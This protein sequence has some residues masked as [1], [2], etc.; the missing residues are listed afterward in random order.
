MAE[1]YHQR[2]PERSVFYRVLF[3]YFDSFLLEYEN[4]FEREYGYLRPVVQEVV[5]KY[6]DC[7]NPKCG[8]ARIRCPDC[9]TARL[10]AFSC[11]VRGFCPSCHAKRIE[12]WGE[13]MREELILDT[14]HRQVVF[15]IPKMLRIFFKYDRSLLSGLCL[16]GKEAILKYLK[17]AAGRELTP[18]IIAVI[19]SF[20]SRINLHQHLHFLVSEG[21]Q[22]REGQSQGHK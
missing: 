14:P 7:G 17:A 21:G 11:K 2:H 4:R 9:G 18:G 8:F 10:L 12:E 22:D 3:H 6:L 16:C 15:T 20:G 13:W 1:I 19:Q 5:D